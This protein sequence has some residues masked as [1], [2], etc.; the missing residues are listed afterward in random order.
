MTLKQSRPLSGPVPLTVL[1][2]SG[3]LLCNRL[4][5]CNVFGIRDLGRTVPYTHELLLLMIMTG[6]GFACCVPAFMLGKAT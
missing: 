5:I 4:D 6:D 3:Q 1:S 2:R